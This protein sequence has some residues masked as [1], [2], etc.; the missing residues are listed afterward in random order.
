MLSAVYCMANLDAL[1]VYVLVFCPLLVPFMH[2]RANS[3]AP[4]GRTSPEKET[5]WGNK[6]GWHPR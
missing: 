4:I 2:I 1:F 3:Y 6:L 5:A